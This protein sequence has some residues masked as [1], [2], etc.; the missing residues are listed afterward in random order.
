MIIGIIGR[1]FSGKSTVFRALSGDCRIEHK[2]GISRSRIEVPDPRIRQLVDLYHPAK[3]GYVTVDV[4]DLGAVLDAGS[5][6]RA[7]TAPL[8]RDSDCLVLVVGA[9]GIADG[10]DVRSHVQTLIDEFQV[11]DQIQIE[12]G[13]ER[14]RKERG[15]PV[16]EQLLA[17]CLERLEQG[18][19]LRSM[20]LNEA[21]ARLL[22]GF[23]FLTLKP[24]LVL[25]NESDR[26]C[27]KAT[28]PGLDDICRRY[29]LAQFRMSA[30][31]EEEFISLAAEEQAFFLAELGFEDVARERFLATAYTSLDLISFFTVGHDEVR[32]WSIKHDT[33]AVKAAG[34]I[35]SDLERG[36]IRAEVMRYEDILELRDEAR[37]KAAG[38]WR[39]VGK[40]YIMQDG[41][42]VNFRFNV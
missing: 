29:Q 24:L 31:L 40:E 4:A 9:Y 13:L 36:F 32:A 6:V 5:R 1:P 38:K 19:M 14:L 33:C 8:L 39:L 23:R 3:V 28:Y 12:S 26:N 30:P 42:V 11:L 34:R 7:G 10:A 18:D 37:V 20:M 15:N 22:S 41:D 16:L 27:N 35:H 21:E 25:I 2:Q 17:R